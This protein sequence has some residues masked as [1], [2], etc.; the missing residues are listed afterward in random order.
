[1]FPVATRLVLVPAYK[2]V[3]EEVAEEL[4]SNILEG[5]CRS[6]EKLEEVDVL[7]LVECDGRCD[8]LGTECRVTA[9]DDVFQIGR[10]DFGGG[11]VAGEDLVCE[12]LEGQVLPL[13]SPVVGQ[14]RNLLRNEQTAIGGETLQ[15]NFL[16]GEL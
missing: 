15:N 13:G 5:E 14:C 12:V 6:V 10:W 1:V 7:L 8:I 4:K 2:E 9:V 11:D 3:L 16:K